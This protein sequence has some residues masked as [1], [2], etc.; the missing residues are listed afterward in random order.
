[1]GGKIMHG[2]K[3]NVHTSNKITHTLLKSVHHFQKRMRTNYTYY[4]YKI[5]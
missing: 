3:K 4:I 5:Y 2:F 1:M